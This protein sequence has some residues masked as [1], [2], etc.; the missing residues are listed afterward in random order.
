MNCQAWTVKTP[1]GPLRVKLFWLF[2]K[3]GCVVTESC[4]IFPRGVAVS[5]MEIGRQTSGLLPSSLIP[6]LA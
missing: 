6:E 4:G 2:Y 5:T 1:S 3:I